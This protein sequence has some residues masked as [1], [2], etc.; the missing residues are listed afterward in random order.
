MP[1]TMLTGTY[2]TGESVSDAGMAALNLTRHD[3]CPTWNYTLRPRSITPPDS[4]LDSPSRELV[5]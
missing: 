1:T 4:A 2:Q 5:T 3:V